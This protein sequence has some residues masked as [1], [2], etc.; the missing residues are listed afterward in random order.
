MINITI[1][2]VSLTNW[3]AG[4]ENSYSGNMLFNTFVK[5]NTHRFSLE[6]AL[7]LGLGLQKQT[8]TKTRKTDDKIDFSSKIGF[9]LKKQ[10]ICCCPIEF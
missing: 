7:D 9:L 5:Y 3:A 8:S 1:S 6:H 10:I 2:Q 4:G